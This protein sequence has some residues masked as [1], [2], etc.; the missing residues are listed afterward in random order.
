MK[1]L[2]NWH[3]T[4]QLLSFFYNYYL[5]YYYNMCLELLYNSIFNY[6]CCYNKTP[7]PN[8]HI[9]F[10]QKTGN[11]THT[12]GFIIDNEGKQIN[13]DIYFNEIEG[14]LKNTSYRTFQQFI[15]KFDCMQV[16]TTLV[17]IQ[18]IL[19]CYIYLCLQCTQYTLNIILFE[20]HCRSKLLSCLSNYYSFY[21][22]KMYQ[23]SLYKSIFYCYCYVCYCTK[24]SALLNESCSYNHING[25]ISNN[26]EYQINP[27][28]RCNNRGEHGKKDKYNQFIRTFD[29]IGLQVIITLIGTNYFTL[30][31]Y[32]IQSM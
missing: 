16:T 17:K 23:M 6:Y 14:L 26:E 15:G 7:N 28:N 12:G 20:W 4:S 11:Y 18:I 21:Y 27:G 32:Y 2:P 24:H 25:E 29:Y 30:P 31:V 13:L 22:Y 5:A 10:V 9:T 8:E 1:V 19:P 3:I